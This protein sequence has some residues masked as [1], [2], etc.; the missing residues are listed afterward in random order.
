MEGAPSFKNRCGYYTMHRLVTDPPLLLITFVLG[1]HTAKK[2]IS[3]R[4][5]TAAGSCSPVTDIVAE[6]V[7]YGQEAQC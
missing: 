4:R 2:L 6:T 3:Q 5:D 7:R 1:K